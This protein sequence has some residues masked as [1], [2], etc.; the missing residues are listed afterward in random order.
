MPKDPDANNRYEWQSWPPDSLEGMPPKRRRLVVWGLLCF[1]LLGAL[2]DA[3]LQT[4][5]VPQPWST[6]VAFMVLGAVL[7]PLVRA[8]ASEARSLRAEGIEVPRYATTRKTVLVAAAVCGALWIAFAVFLIVGTP[9]S[10]LLPIAA[11]LW[12]T[13]QVRQ[14]R[15]K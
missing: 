7:V 6:L 12:L 8:A 15:W 9:I 1:F 14:L 11:A 13:Y 4:V 2:L 5:K 3:A 10:P